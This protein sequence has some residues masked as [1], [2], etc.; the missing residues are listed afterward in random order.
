MDE[1]YTIKIEKS[2]AY[3][4]AN[5]A[6]GALRALETFSQLAYFI[7]VNGYQKLIINDSTSIYDHPRFSYRGLMLDTSRH[8]IPL[9][10]LRKQLDAMSY[11]KFNVFHWHIVDDQ[12]FPFES[13][14]YPDLTKNGAYTPAHVY[15]Q[16][17]VRT[18]IDHARLRGIRVIPEF[19]SPGHVNAFGKTFPQFITECWANGKPRQAIYSVQGQAEILNPT[20]ED[21]YPVLENILAEIKQVFPDEYI[22]LGNDEVYY[23]CWK[24]NPSIR[25]WM[26]TMNFTDYHHLEAYYSTKILDKAKKL[27][28]KV[29]VWQ[30]VYDNGVRPDK[31]T[32]IQIW[33]DTSILPE[34]KKWY[35][36]LSDITAKGYQAILSSPW[37][38]NFVSYGYQ[39][40]YKF[41]KVDP[42][43][44]FTGTPDQAKL[45]IGG[46][47]ALWSEYVDGNNLESRLWP[48]AS[49][50]AE[51]LW[52]DASVNDPEEAKF[53]LD[54]QRCRLLRRG[55]PASPVLNGYCG[56]YEYGMEKSVI[57]DK[58]FN[59][60]W[61][62][63]F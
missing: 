35:E 60:G 27:N 42:L 19:D 57:F 28:K 55:I 56:D 32:V 40:W 26:K 25:E 63:C 13:K 34:H 11:H 18:V 7:D 16:E 49:A 31:S 39:E 17:D 47:T 50:I 37:Y 21:M 8:F 2:V 61:P 10:L 33:K 3:L 30:D 4:K 29:S 1:S 62:T 58:S 41:Y 53:R 14:K 22:H 5:S 43:S 9:P 45:I 48:R 44:N 36:Y 12:S 24:S 51:R 38:I 52:S 59:Y 46:E 15:T 23:E 54:E 6:W 20:L